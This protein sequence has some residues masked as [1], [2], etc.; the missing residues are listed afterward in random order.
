[1]RKYVRTQFTKD[2]TRIKCGIDEFECKQVATP[3][4]EEV[5]QP[6]EFLLHNQ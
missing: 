6:G 2:K 3:V 1:M 5:T 4:S